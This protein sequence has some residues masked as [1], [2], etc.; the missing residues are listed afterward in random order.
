MTKLSSF[1]RPKKPGGFAVLSKLDWQLS[2]RLLE[3]CV[4]IIV[5][6][7]DCNERKDVL[8]NNTVQAGYGQC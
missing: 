6:S 7:G 4:F 1:R 2:E 8:A 3:N 5:H